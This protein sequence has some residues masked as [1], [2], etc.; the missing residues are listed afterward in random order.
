MAVLVF[1]EVS[2]MRTA[3]GAGKEPDRSEKGRVRTKKATVRMES[4]RSD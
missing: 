2:G 1:E 3:R 4:T